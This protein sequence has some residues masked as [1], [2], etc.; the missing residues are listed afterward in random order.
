MYNALSQL[1]YVA[2]LV[3]A[4]AGFL[5]G[6]LWYSPLLFGKSWMT[7]MKITEEMMKEKCAQKGMAGFFIKGFIYTVVSTW[8]LAVLIQSRAPTNMIKGVI[9]G[10]FVALVLVGARMLNG[11]VWEQRSAK[12]MAIL[13][14][15]ELVMFCVQG[16]ILGAWL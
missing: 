9:I 14:G 16:V 13:I 6:W 10:A 12:L 15:H 11:S 3:T 5:V 4:V 8:G 2:V 7:E 1:N